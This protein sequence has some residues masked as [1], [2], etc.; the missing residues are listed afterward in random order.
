MKL[1]PFISLKGT[2]ENEIFEEEPELEFQVEEGEVF[3]A[4]ELIIGECVHT[5]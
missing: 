3:R 1:F 5:V 2:F 4:L